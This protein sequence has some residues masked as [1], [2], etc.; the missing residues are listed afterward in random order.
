MT[1]TIE[2]RLATLE[3]ENADLKA[4]ARGF[5]IAA[6]GKQAGTAAARRAT[7]A[8]SSRR[9]WRRWRCRRR[10]NFAACLRSS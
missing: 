9:R 3:R 1:V 7:G 8:E 5:A 10:M 6:A 4:R 2:K